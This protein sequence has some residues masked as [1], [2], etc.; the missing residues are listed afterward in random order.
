MTSL[1]SSEQELEEARC[2][3]V[4]SQSKQMK[5]DPRSGAS[6]GHAPLQL[7]APGVIIWREY[8][9]PGHDIIDEISFR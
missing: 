7:V 3:S 4:S 6:V 2:S 1:L 8:H 5:I 9:Y